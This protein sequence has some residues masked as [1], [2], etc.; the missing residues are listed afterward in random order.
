M[1]N[2][3]GRGIPFKGEGAF[4]INDACPLHGSLA[5]SHPAPPPPSEETP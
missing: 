4:W 1:D 5:L 2:A 3:R